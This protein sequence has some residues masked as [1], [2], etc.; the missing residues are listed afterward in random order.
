MASLLAC[1]LH[2]HRPYG[3]HFNPPQSLL[4]WTCG[5]RTLSAALTREI[6]KATGYRLRLHLSEDGKEIWQGEEEAD[7]G[8]IFDLKSRAY[9]M[10][11][12]S[13]LL[14]LDM[15]LPNWRK[16]ILWIVGRTRAEPWQ[17]KYRDTPSNLI[18]LERLHGKARGFTVY[19]RWV[20]GVAPRRTKGRTPIDRVELVSRYK[21]VPGR[22]AVLIG[23]ARR[24]VPQSGGGIR[25]RDFVF[26]K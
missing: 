13:R 8:P 9:P 23:E 20:G 10:S 11:D 19:D 17:I 1:V 4:T 15:D 7:D 25:E 2:F 12:G 26:L 21:L 16:T 6:G 3:A 14:Q 18:K 24:V 5:S 22:G